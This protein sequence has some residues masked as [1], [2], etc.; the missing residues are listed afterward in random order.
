MVHC[1]DYRKLNAVTR[2]DPYP[3]PQVD[4]SLTSISNAKWFSAMD[5]AAGYW[6]VEMNPKDREKNAFTIPMGLHKFG[7][8]PI[9]LTNTPAIFQRLMESCLG[10][11]SAEALLIYLD[12]VIL[13]SKDFDP[14]LKHLEFIFSRLQQFGLKLKPLLPRKQV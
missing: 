12:D 13:Y 14:H 9:G 2:K 3:L 7:H 6:Q 8:T 4:E 1:V 5:L 10:D 11:L